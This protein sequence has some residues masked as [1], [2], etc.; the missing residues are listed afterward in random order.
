M[1]AES[2]EPEPDVRDNVRA[3]GGIQSVD[4]ALLILQILARNGRAGVSE[5]AQELGIHKSTAF[6][7][8]A[9]LESRGMV[10]QSVSRGK[11]Q[12][13]VGVLRLASAVSGRM[14]IVQ[15]AR[16][17]LERLAD[18][19]GETVNLAVRRSGWAVNLDQAMGPSPLASYDWIGNLTPLHATA[20]GKIFLAAL[21]P[22]ER[23]TVLG[24]APLARYTGATLVDRRRLDAELAQVTTDG[25]ATTRSELED[26][27][28]AIAVAVR[29][30]HGAVVGSISASGPGVRFD[31]SAPEVRSAMVAAGIEVSGRLGHESA[32]RDRPD[33]EPGFSGTIR[34]GTR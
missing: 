24:T 30:H 26:G 19:L 1:A 28:N 23:L 14:S 8:L 11:Y 21:N 31:P 22:A 25:V 10:E 4:R 18:E 29:D 5:I 33:T 15:Q 17:S 34:S 3:P 2:T 32:F 20:S 16:P 27:L 9:A 7:L 6:R 12:V 13:G